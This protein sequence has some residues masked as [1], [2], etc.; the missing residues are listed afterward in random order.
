MQLYSGALGV[1]MRPLAIWLVLAV[2]WLTLQQARALV[3]PR[4][5]MIDYAG[6]RALDQAYGNSLRDHDFSR[7]RTEMARILQ[8]ADLAY[9]GAPVTWL[10]TNLHDL[11]PEDAEALILFVRET[12]MDSWIRTSL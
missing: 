12:A 11:R 7:L 4:D 3:G 2:H 10:S 5:Q 9:R 8:D 1:T 6:R